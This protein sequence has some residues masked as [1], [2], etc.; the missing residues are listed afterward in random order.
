MDVSFIQRGCKAFYRTLIK[1]GW[2][3]L[4]S[5][6]DIA[7]QGLDACIRFGQL[8]AADTVAVHAVTTVSCAD[9]R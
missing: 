5:A 6:T 9:R 4:L 2:R 8:I 3:R 7:A 1:F